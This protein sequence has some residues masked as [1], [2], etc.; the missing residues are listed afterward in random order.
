MYSL[1]VISFIRH[2]LTKSFLDCILP[3]CLQ[4]ANHE[5]ETI[6][7]HFLT[8]TKTDHPCHVHVLFD[9]MLCIT[10]IPSLSGT[11]SR[12]AQPAH[13][14]QCIVE[15]LRSLNVGVTAMK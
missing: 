4:L 13:F 1:G 5:K 2:N 9:L 12:L 3:F 10:M 8:H 15:L 14:E 6:T 11:S 7:K